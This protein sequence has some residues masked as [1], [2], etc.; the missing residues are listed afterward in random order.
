[1]PAN[2]PSPKAKKHLDILSRLIFRGYSGSFD[3]NSNLE[4][5]YPEADYVLN[6]SEEEQIEFLDLANTHHVLVRALRALEQAA[7][8][9]GIENMATR[10]NE[11]LQREQARI[12]HAIEVL[13]P[14]CDALEDA[15]CTTTVIKSLDHWPDLGS[16]LDLYTT[17]DPAEVARVMNEQFGAEPVERSW[18]DQLANKWNFSVPGLPELVEIH[19]R[20]LGQTGE[21]KKMARRVVQRRV[22]KKINGHSFFVPAP[23]ERVVI[24]TL[25]RMYRHFYFRL[26]DMCDV[27]SLLQNNEIDFNELRRAANTGG[28]WRGVSTFLFL[29]M[30]YAQSF[31]A[32]IEL[33][34]NII[35]SSYSPHIRVFVGGQFLRVPKL[36][37]ASLYA[38]Q[39]A[40]AGLRGD[41]RAMS[42]LPLLPP[43]A[44]S[45]LV[46]YRVTG[47]D[48]G[49]W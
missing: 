44:L 49:V 32:K 36:P 34:A 26:C 13:N 7:K 31:G 33:P 11:A 37:A 29:V 9:L 5:I 6:L 12:T 18:G 19:V 10:C 3:P 40:N 46:A 15:G 28:I 25:Q 48:K 20:Y 47:S 35:I 43:L 17:G 16:D 38:S 1:M 23:E 21:H 24:S 8:Q 41:L 4:R 39:L 14:I 30:K 42:R 45:A 22:R 2:S 27:A